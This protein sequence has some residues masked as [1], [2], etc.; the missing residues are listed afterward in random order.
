MTIIFDPQWLKA[1]RYWAKRLHIWGLY[2]NL[3][4]IEKWHW[5]CR[6]AGHKTPDLSISVDKCGIHFWWLGLQ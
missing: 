2:R 5:R 6:N 1:W 3:Q 4:A